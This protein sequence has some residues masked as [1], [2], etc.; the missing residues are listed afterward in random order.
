MGAVIALAAA[1]VQQFSGNVEFS[2][3]FGQS[4]GDG[5][6]I[7]RFQKAPAGQDLLP[8][9]TGCQGMLLLHGEQIHIAL[10]GNVKAVPAG[11]D[12]CPV[13]FLQRFPTDGTNKSQPCSPPCFLILYHTLFF[14]F[15]QTKDKGC[16]VHAANIYGSFSFGDSDSS[17]SGSGRYQICCPDF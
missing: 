3:S 16:E 11:T 15:R 13:R 8:G 5:G 1:Y 7:A 17:R 9:I 4:F 2:G 10:P 12:I 6:I 14:R